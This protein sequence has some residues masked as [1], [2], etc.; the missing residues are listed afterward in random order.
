MF[1]YVKPY[2]PDLKVRQNELYKAVYCTLCRRQKKLTG[3]FSAFSLSYDFVFLALVRSAITKEELSVENGRCAYFPFKKK[4]V[5][6][7]S[8]SLDYTACVAGVLTYYKI[9]DDIADSRGLCKLKY[10]PLL[11]VF[12]H[13]RKKALKHGVPD[14]QIRDYLLRLSELERQKLPSPDLAAEIFGE[15]LGCVAS[16]G[17]EDLEQYAL[18]EIFNC[19]GRW[20]Y[21]IDAVDDLA[22]DMNKGQFNPFIDGNDIN[23]EIIKATLQMTLT[24]AD[25]CITKI[26]FR[27]PDVAQIIENILLLGTSEIENKV[28]KKAI[29]DN[30]KMKGTNK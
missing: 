14:T 27:D 28:I 5:I 26:K 22:E 21:I 9:K 15:L 24:R 19:I 4:K 23:F 17:V 29:S 12:S 3:Y 20:I 10:L 13:S 11:P 8:Y 6:S 25:E 18:E 16:Y 30:M 1:G 2:V 7:G